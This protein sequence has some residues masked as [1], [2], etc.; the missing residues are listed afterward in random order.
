MSGSRYWWFR[1]RQNGQRFAVSL[2]TPDEGEA[3][4]KAQAIL[5]QGLIAAEEYNPL[6]PPT[7]RRE[8]HGLIEQYLKD[9]QARNK[10]PLRAGTADTHKYILEKWVADCGISRVGDISASKIDQWL[11]ALRAQGKSQDTRWTYGQRARSFVTYLIPKYLPTTTLAGFIL[12]EPSA[13]GRKNWIRSTEVSKILGATGDDQDLKF[14]LLCGF[15][16]G[17]RRNEVSEARV[18]WF[19]LENGLLHVSNNAD[20]VTKDRYNRTIPLT[21][22]F[23]KFLKGYLAGR[24]QRQHVLA[25][26]KTTK[27]ENKYR[28]DTS[29]R[30][31]SHFERLKINCTFHDMRRSFASTRA[32][33]GVSIYKIATWLG[34]RIEVVQRSYGYLS[35]QDR[36]INQGV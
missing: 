15:D 36:D 10:K 13:V 8:I 3:I 24:D 6:E 31:R 16:A 25:P 2:R 27:G 14:A 4:T 19:D 34:D 32:S 29:K 20:F 21:D 7:R 30:V 5:A 9:A 1:Y 18:N 22:R 23:A 12:P 11:T 26:E 35:P 17:L 33:A 28:Y